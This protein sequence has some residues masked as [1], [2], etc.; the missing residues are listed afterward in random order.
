MIHTVV[1]HVPD[2]NEETEDNYVI[3]ALLLIEK[4]GQIIP[5][6]FQYKEISPEIFEVISG[7]PL[8]DGHTAL[9]FSAEIEDD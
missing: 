2:W 8:P 9:R 5:N 3:G 7:Y 4:R 6:T 1:G